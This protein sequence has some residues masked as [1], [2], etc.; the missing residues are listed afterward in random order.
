MNIYL[1][2]ALD[3]WFEKI[4]RKSCTG[5]A[6]IIRYCD[7][8]VVCFQYQTDTEKFR[9]ELGKRLAKFGLEMEPTKT[10]VIAF[11][12]FAVQNAKS[13][14]EKPETFDFMGF[15]HYC[16]KRRNGTGFRIKRVTARKKFTAKLKDF[17]EW[18]KRA[19]T[20]KTAEIWETSFQ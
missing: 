14:R 19:R 10:R 3:L 13:R 9:W 17:M 4:I 1:H 11:G 20:E 18:L 12:C 7:D 15:T 8:F 5:F 6:W 16:G 2:Y